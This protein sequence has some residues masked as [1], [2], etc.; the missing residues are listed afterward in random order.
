MNEQEVQ[1]K[2]DML[3]EEMTPENIA[4]LSDENLERL[5]DLLDKVEEIIEG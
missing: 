1:E 2:V 4:A 5:M 3:I